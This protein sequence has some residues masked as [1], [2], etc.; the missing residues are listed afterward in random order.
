M[1]KLPIILIFLATILTKGSVGIGI[2]L[3]LLI[4]RNDGML[5]MIMW[6]SGIAIV[7]GIAG[8]VMAVI[9]VSLD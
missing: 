9:A 8:S 6:M 7:S 1:N 2:I 3:G 4:A 5:P